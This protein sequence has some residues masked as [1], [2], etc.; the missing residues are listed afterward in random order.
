[1]GEGNGVI[2]R[3]EPVTMDGFVAS[4]LVIRQSDS[5]ARSTTSDT[6]DYMRG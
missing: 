4:Y 6:V 2:K 5:Y 1:M 3:L